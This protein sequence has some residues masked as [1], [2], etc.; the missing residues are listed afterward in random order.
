M[1]VVAAECDE[2]PEI[3]IHP[4]HDEPRGAHH[5]E[6]ALG[7]RELLVELRTRE[8]PQ[9]EGDVGDQREGRFVDPVPGQGRERVG[10]EGVHE[11]LCAGAIAGFQTTRSQQA[12][13]ARPSR[14]AGRRE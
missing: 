8:D 5:H 12:L 2:L 13:Q 3:A 10:D 11:R 9:L 6:L 1:V 7:R 14:A 4:S